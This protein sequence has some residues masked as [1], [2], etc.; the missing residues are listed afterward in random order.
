MPEGVSRQWRFYRIEGAASA[1]AREEFEALPEHGRA[2]LW[3]AMKRYR[4]GE[5]RGREID[6]VTGVDGLF[7]L[8]VQV[9]T[10]PFRVLFFRPTPVHAVALLAV[11]KNQR[12][13]PKGDREK[14]ERRMKDWKRRGQ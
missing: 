11:Y 8:R 10:D 12:K 4:K 7:E 3:E 1:I 13:L 5:S 6:P 14:A 2:A 9:G